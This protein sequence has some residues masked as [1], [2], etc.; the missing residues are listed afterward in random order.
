MLCVKRKKNVP[1][2]FDILY[3][4]QQDIYNVLKYKSATYVLYIVNK[5][6]KYIYRLY[7]IKLDGAKIV[8]FIGARGSILRVPYYLIFT[9]VLDLLVRGYA[10]NIH[11]ARVPR[12]PR[13]S[14]IHF[15]PK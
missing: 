15:Q 14:K 4:T 5:K 6:K 3:Y 9:D 12:Y 10:V 8:S 13:T 2:I 7:K 1:L 11:V